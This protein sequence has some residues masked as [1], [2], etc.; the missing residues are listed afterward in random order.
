MKYKLIIV[1]I[2]IFSSCDN[3]N[4]EELKFIDC[5]N[6]KLNEGDDSSSTD[7]IKDLKGMELEAIRLEYMKEPTKEGYADFFNLFRSDAN[8]VSSTLMIKLTKNTP[9]F[10]N[11]SPALISYKHKMCM[12][13]TNR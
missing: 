11:F 10:E 6:S 1:F 13:D 9:N 3:K 4:N 12:Y 7:F 8:D 2:L 5:F